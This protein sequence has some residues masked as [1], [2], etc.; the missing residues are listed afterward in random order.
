MAAGCKALVD[1]GWLLPAPAGVRAKGILAGAYPV[2]PKLWDAL[3]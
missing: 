1:A 2:N 3:T